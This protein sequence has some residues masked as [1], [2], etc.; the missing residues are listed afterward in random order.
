[1]NLS[2]RLDK[3]AEMLRTKQEAAGRGRRIVKAVKGPKDRNTVLDQMVSNGE[4]TED[5]RGDVLLIRQVIVPWK[6]A[7]E[8]VKPVKELLAT[9]GNQGS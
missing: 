3:L 5:Q 1:M 6:T 7:V 2:N 4:I 9:L 8:P